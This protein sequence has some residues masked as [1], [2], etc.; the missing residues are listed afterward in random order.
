MTESNRN[1]L[2]NDTSV[3]IHHVGYKTLS[4]SGSTLLNGKVARLEER[5]ILL[6]E[7]NVVP[8]KID[9]I[10][11]YGYFRSYQ[12]DNNVP[13]YYF[14]GMIE[15]YIPI[16]SKNFK[17]RLLEHRA[18]RNKKIVDAEKN[19]LT[20]INMVTATIPWLEYLTSVDE[21]KKKYRLTNDKFILN[22]SDTVGRFITHGDN[23]QIDLNLLAPKE[24][25]KK[26]LFG[27]TSIIKNN[28]SAETYDC[29]DV[30][31]L[32]KDNILVQSHYSDILFQHK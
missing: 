19:R 15:Y 24:E 17:F 4:I 3:T 25:E 1:E 18:F 27:Y 6:N 7:V 20:T 29:L 21:I 28:T 23:L 32:Q 5:N 16:K 10:V 26:T 14:D 12:L 31:K 11:L 30:E 2:L 8:K 13:K 22:K 9:Y